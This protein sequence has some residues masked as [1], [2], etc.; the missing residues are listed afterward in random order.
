VA[1]AVRAAKGPAVAFCRSGTRSITTWAKGQLARGE[2]TRDE[3][4]GLARNAG[5]DLSG[6]L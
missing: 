2:R 5:Y 3:L 4:I 6:S 1:D